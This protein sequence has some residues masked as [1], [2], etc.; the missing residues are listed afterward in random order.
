MDPT[1]AVLLM[2][3]ALIIGVIGGIH[4]GLSLGVTAL[5]GTWLMFGSY[6]LAAGQVAPHRFSRCVTL[7]SRLS[8]CLS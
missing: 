2:L 8:R 1:T 4:I 6:E 3:V 7:C 5:V